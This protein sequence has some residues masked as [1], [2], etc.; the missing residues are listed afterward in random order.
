MSAQGQFANRVA[1]V[2]GGSS[3]IGR[4][5]AIEFADR[6]AAVVVAD[7]NAN[8]GQAVVSEIEDAGGDATFVETDV[9]DPSQVSEMVDTA[10]ETYERLDFAHNNAGVRGERYPITDYPDEAWREVIDVNLTGVWNCLKHELR[11]LESQGDGGAIVNT[12][13]VV[14]KSGLPNGTSYAAAKHGIVGLTKSVAMEVGDE[15]IR[16]NAVCPGYI[17]TP[18]IRSEGDRVTTDEEALEAIRE[19]HPL[20][21]LGDPDEVAETAV[22]LCSDNATYVTGDAINV[23]GGFLAGKG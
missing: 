3:G 16:V 23:D 5:S 17:D 7:I 14:G 9:S 15:D 12:A 6:G 22:W 21:R 4:Q 20:G 8:E 2:T 11:Q 19:M 18:M 1:I 10:V 13:S